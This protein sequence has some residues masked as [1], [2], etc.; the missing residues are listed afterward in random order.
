MQEIECPRD[1]RPGVME[2]LRCKCMM[3][4]PLRSVQ[5][6]SGRTPAAEKLGKRCSPTDPRYYR[7]GPTFLAELFPWLPGNPTQLF[8]GTIM[9]G[10]PSTARTPG[11]QQP[12]R[13]DPDYRWVP[14]S[15]AG[16]P[17]PLIDLVRMA[18]AL[19]AWEPRKETE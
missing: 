10:R 4:L 8:E 7:G 3:R 19:H 17:L 5:W 15:L 1:N 18:R 14:R 11:A 13:P 9:V 16:I 6:C 12:C 2:N